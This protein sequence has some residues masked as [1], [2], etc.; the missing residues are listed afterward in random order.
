MAHNGLER[1][2]RSLDPFF[3]HYRQ[4]EFAEAIQADATCPVPLAKIFL[5]PFGA[6]HF[7]IR[8]HPGPT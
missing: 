5:F 7:S 8:G 2:L 6:N 4:H 1:L 3:W